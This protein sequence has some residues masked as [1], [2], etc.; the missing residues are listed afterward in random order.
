MVNIQGIINTNF[1]VVDQLTVELTNIEI[2]IE[3]IIREHTKENFK[4]FLFYSTSPEG[5]QQAETQIVG[6]KEKIDQLINLKKKIE[7]IWNRIEALTA[8]VYGSP[9]NI[10]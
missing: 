2:E 6:L 9:N 3:N 10:N 1:L 7:K 8:K 5:L 4:Q